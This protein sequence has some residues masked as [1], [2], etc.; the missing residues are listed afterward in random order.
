[1][2]SMVASKNNREHLAFIN[3]FAHEVVDFSSQY[4]SESGTGFTADNVTGPSQIYPNYCDSNAACAF[5]ILF[6]MF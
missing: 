1:M 2:S 5:V 4:G 6:F 3:Q